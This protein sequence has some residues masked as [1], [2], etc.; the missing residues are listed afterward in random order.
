MLCFT[1]ER[2][3]T[4]EFEHVQLQTFWES[5]KLW[6]FSKS[7]NFQ[8]TVRSWYGRRVY[9]ILTSYKNFADLKI[10][11]RFSAKNVPDA[12]DSIISKKLIIHDVFWLS[13][14]ARHEVVRSQSS[15]IRII[16]PKSRGQ[17]SECLN[18]PGKVRANGG[19]AGLCVQWHRKLGSLDRTH[20]HLR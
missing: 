12:F 17:I 20:A 16:N 1:L 14:I 15:P 10:P 6:P 13:R 7:N 5:I 18:A 4:R 3:G 11:R 2:F 9:S 19:S 8:N